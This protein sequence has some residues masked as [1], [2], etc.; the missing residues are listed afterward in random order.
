MTTVP[1]SRLLQPAIETALFRGKTIV[2]YG[3]RRTGK[4]SLLRSLLQKSFNRSLYLDCG[5]ARTLDML[6]NRT[7]GELRPLVGDVALLLLDDAHR[8]P[9]IGVTL[10][11]L[12]EDFPGLQVVATGAWLL[13]DLA[14][15]RGLPLM[16]GKTRFYLLPPGVVELQSLEWGE[17]S[18]LERRVLYGM[19]PEVILAENEQQALEGLLRTVVEGSLLTR[20]RGLPL[21]VRQP[22]SLQ[23]L[24]KYVALHVGQEVSYNEIGTELGLDKVTVGR[25]VALLEQANIL[26]HLP[27][28][29]RKL[30]KELG[31]L[32]KVY[33]Y[34]T[35]LRNAVLQN[36]NPLHLRLDTKAMWENFFI[37]ERIKVNRGHARLTSAYFWRTYDGTRLDYLEE[38][39]GRL[40]AYA[41]QWVPSRWQA[42]LTFVK[43]YPG[44]AV[45]VAR[46]ENFTEFLR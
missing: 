28:F 23:R 44:S 30:R 25:Y 37:S 13:F 4:T 7:T 10:K 22:D 2:I 24:L 45:N 43:T 18:F 39:N 33:F 20:P 5:D 29:K 31:K 42:P 19:Y 38:E 9:N 1:F 12:A 16:A 27:S 14:N 8:V 46:P 15:G 17:H 21:A 11:I 41:C 26:F 36:F 32:R 3:G 35:G 6:A 40:S 34:D